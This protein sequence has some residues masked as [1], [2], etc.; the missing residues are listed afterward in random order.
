MR[1]KSVRLKDL[2]V[3]PDPQSLKGGSNKTILYKT[4]TMVSQGHCN[5]MSKTDLECKLVL[6]SSPVRCEVLELTLLS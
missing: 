4:M 3:T 1:L 6:E 2:E 5:I